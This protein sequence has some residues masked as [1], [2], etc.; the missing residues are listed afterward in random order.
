[1]LRHA[2]LV[3]TALLVTLELI[4]QWQCFSQA[5]TNSKDMVIQIP[6]TSVHVL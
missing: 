3:G 1:M 4:W 2:Q 6:I 5:A